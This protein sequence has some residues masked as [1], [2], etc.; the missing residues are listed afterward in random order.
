MAK[1]TLSAIGKLK[2]KPGNPQS[3]RVLIIEDSEDDALLI[4]RALKKGGYTT[5]HEIVE[6]AAAMHQ[7]LKDKT[8]DIVMSDYGMPHFSGEKAIALLKETNIDIPLIIVSGTIGEETAA[9]CM[10]LGA[11]DYF[12]KSNL[13]RL[14]AAVGRELAEAQSRRERRIAE[15]AVIASEFR[16]KELFE[17]MSSCVAIYEARADGADFVFKDFNRA[18]EIAEKIDRKKAK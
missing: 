10:R 17:N 7:A 15:Q 12:I 3:L 14:S 6:T 4:I 5:E 8:W 18:A 13:T 11:S 9:A 2:P 16:F 1:K